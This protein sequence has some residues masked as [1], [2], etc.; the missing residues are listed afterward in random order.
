[1]LTKAVNHTDQASGYE[2]DVDERIVA[3]IPAW[4]E[5]KKKKKAKTAIHFTKV[6]SL[7]L[8]ETKKNTANDQLIEMFCSK[9]CNRSFSDSFGGKFRNNETEEETERE[10]DEKSAT[11][12]K[13]AEQRR[14][15]NTKGK[16]RA[17]SNRLNVTK[18]NRTWS[19]H[20]GAQHSTPEQAVIVLCG[21]DPSTSQQALHDE[22]AWR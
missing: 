7:R 1:M 15:G 21:T 5:M 10:R 20:S 13:H 17:S 19:E 18:D 4:H 14:Q 2:F 12:H 16:T 9:S 11:E 6:Q 22:W 8:K 3:Y